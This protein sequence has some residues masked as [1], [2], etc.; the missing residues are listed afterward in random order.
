MATPTVRRDLR[1][2]V[3]RVIVDRHVDRLS[4]RHVAVILFLQRARIVF[5]VVEDVEG[6]VARI[7]DEARPDLVR[8]EQRRQ[9]RP[10]QAVWMSCTASLRSAR[11]CA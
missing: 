2:I 7:L 3:I 1:R 10:V 5:K 9:P 4:C 6:A 11:A 8:G